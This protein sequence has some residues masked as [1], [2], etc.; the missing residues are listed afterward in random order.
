MQ[1]TENQQNLANAYGKRVLNK[2]LY[3]RG[4]IP[5]ALY[6]IATEKLILEID[7]LDKTCSN[8]SIMHKK[9]V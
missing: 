4:A 3:K 6:D 9:A 1:L 8:E 2:E 5:K 7:R